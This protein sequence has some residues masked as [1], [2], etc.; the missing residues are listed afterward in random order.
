MKIVKKDLLHHA[1]A[2][3]EQHSRACRHANARIIRATCTARGAKSGMSGQEKLE[4]WH[5]AELA[6]LEAQQQVDR[7]GQAAADPRAA[8]LF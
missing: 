7:L 5:A 2:S 6:A 8:E 3:K 1:T 4:A